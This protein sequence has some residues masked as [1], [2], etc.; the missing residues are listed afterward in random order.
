MEQN[1][2][3]NCESCTHNAKVTA[4]ETSK[5]PVLEVEKSTGLVSRTHLALSLMKQNKANN[6]ESWGEV[7]IRFIIHFN[8]DNRASM[9]E[10]IRVYITIVF[11]L[12]ICKF[13][14]VLWADLS[15]KTKM[16]QHFF[17]L[18][19]SNQRNS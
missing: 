12:I 19:M 10:T 13:P 1:R 5:A 11:T 6:S 15:L 18:A 2:A 14:E 9:L 16:E 17:G 7:K 8:V 3:K 4:L